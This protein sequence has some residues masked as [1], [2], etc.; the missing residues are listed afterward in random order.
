MYEYQIYLLSGSPSASHFRDLDVLW[1]PTYESD[2][3][4]Q[5]PITPILCVS[6]AYFACRRFESQGGAI[7]LADGCWQ[8]YQRRVFIFTAPLLQQS[9]FL[10]QMR[11][12]P[13]ISY[14][15][16]TSF[17]M[18]QQP[19][20]YEP[21]TP[22]DASI[23]VLAICTG[24]DDTP[25]R[26]TMRHIPLTSD[27]LCLSYTWGTDKATHPVL[28]NDQVFLVRDNLWTFLIQ[29]R[30]ANRFE[31]VPIWIDAI[32]INQE[33]IDEKNKQ[34]ALM[35]DIYT[36]ALEV[37]IWLGEGDRNTKQA[38]DFVK[39]HA[40]TGSLSFNP[41][42]ESDIVAVLGSQSQDVKQYWDAF[43][44]LSSLV[45]FTRM[46]I[47]QE[48]LLAK[49]LTIW[50]GNNDMPWNT[51]VN[52]CLFI[53]QSKGPSEA[54]ED[55]GNAKID[56]SPCGA[57]VKKRF[58]SFSAY[59][60]SRPT[61]HFYNLFPSFRDQGCFDIRDKIYALRAMDPK[62]KDFPVDYAADPVI[63]LP[64]TYEHCM[65]WATV[66]FG[67]SLI[68]TLRLSHD[69]VFLKTKECFPGREWKVP[70]N[71]VG[72]LN[73][74]EKASSRWNVD[75]STF[76]IPNREVGEYCQYIKDVTFKI[77]DPAGPTNAMSLCDGDIFLRPGWLNMFLV[78]RSSDKNAAM[79]L[80]DKINAETPEGIY[81][82]NDNI[83]ALDQVLS[84]F[85]FI[86]TIPI[87]PNH[88]PR[89]ALGREE[90]VGSE[91][92]NEPLLLLAPTHEVDVF[93][94]ELEGARFYVS[95]LD[96]GLSLS[97]QQLLAFWR[98]LDRPGLLRENRLAGEKKV[99]R[100]DFY[101]K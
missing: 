71:D 2:F 93:A 64:Q 36:H 55:I 5:E 56:Q 35:G 3:H 77:E 13:E 74:T 19:F 43:D 91:R 40:D 9:K 54:V 61:Y 80:V 94:K 20:R 39:K 59:G 68:K 21:L 72:I 23:R 33:D 11:T 46:W 50:Y 98:V 83:T 53:Q 7:R 62:M 34:V 32:T 78:V 99:E 49:V 44:T 17:G 73:S 48:F 76:T 30:R 101:S 37:I 24:R 87:H 29:A 65:I 27:Y 58:Y 51:F 31:R 85:K 63:L 57:L 28:I 45:Y 89:V 95:R 15:R 70:V 10:C 12:K 69:G 25:L 26:C 6:F 1:S 92:D 86:G 88:T 18:A 100:W 60:V 4:G 38:F 96:F 41:M 67:W 8:I 16:T 47:V 14:R 66:S 79:A 81:A 97:W 52:L 84:T 82:S 42:S 22:A 90:D 75:W